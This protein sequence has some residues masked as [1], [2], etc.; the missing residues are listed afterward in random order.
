M[1]AK[2]ELSMRAEELMQLGIPVEL[3]RTF[4]KVTQDATSHF[5]RVQNTELG[6]SD[7]TSLPQN[8][9]RSLQ[10]TLQMARAGQS[11]SY[12]LTISPQAGFTGTVSFSCSNLPLHAACIF[13]PPNVAIGSAAVNVGVTITT[14]Q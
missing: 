5:V 2:I 9:R 14:S 10:P 11:A 8:S 12:D 1:E 7:S 6:W 13:T 3:R 4:T